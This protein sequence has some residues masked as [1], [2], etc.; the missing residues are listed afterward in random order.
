[1]RYLDRDV[2]QVLEVDDVR[3]LP[4]KS[5]RSLLSYQIG[6]PRI[7]IES[8]EVIIQRIEKG[9]GVFDAARH[10]RSHRGAKLSNLVTRRR[11]ESIA[12]SVGDPFDG[13]LHISNVRIERR[14]R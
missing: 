5:L 11:D 14:E 8:V 13:S 9:T 6:V 7:V 10:Q 12:T 2:A 3:T 1:M 4:A